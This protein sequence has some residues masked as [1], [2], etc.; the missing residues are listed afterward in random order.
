MR[1]L[2]AFALSLFVPAAAA[3]AAANVQEICTT[4]ANR[5]I[6][7]QK[8]NVQLKCGLSGPEW[9]AGFA[10]HFD[11]CVNGDNYKSADRWT[12]FRSERVAACKKA[13]GTTKPMGKPAS[14]DI[15]RT[16]ERYATQ[17]V[18]QHKENTSLECGLRGPEWNAGYAYHYAWCITGNNWRNASQGERLRSQKLAECRTAHA[19]TKPPPG[20]PSG[21][22]NSQWVKQVEPLTRDLLAHLDARLEQARKRAKSGT[23]WLTYKPLDVPAILAAGKAMSDAQRIKAFD[24][25]L[26]AEIA[27]AK[28]NVQDLHLP[29]AIDMVVTVPSGGRIEPGTALMIAGK[30]FGS[31]PGRIYLSYQTRRETPSTEFRKE[32]VVTETVDVAP[33][34]P[35]WADS[36][37]PT[38][39]VARVPVT[40]KDPFLEADREGV[41]Q[42]VL[43]DGATAKTT[44]TVG[45]GSPRIYEVKTADGNGWIRPG[46]EFVVIG[47]N[48]GD[49]P[50][51]TAAFSINEPG[52]MTL[53]RLGGS[54]TYVFDPGPAS[55]PTTTSPHIGISI[56]HW[57]NT[58]IGLKAGTYADKNFHRAAGAWVV[59]ENVKKQRGIKGGLF[60]GPDNL[61]KN[62]SGLEWIDPQAKKNKVGVESKDKSTLLV[63]HTPDCGF[64]DDSGEKGHD[65]FFSDPGWPKDV[66]VIGFTF[67]QIDPEDKYTDADFFVDQAGA[68]LEAAS[69]PIAFAKFVLGRVLDAIFGGGGGYHVYVSWGPDKLHWM[70]GKD[71]IVVSYE[72]DCSLGGRPIIY[73]MS[74]TIIGTK[75][76][77]AKH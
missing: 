59:I 10:Y 35:N 27:A 46:E 61:A 74:F 47:R 20:K 76:A 54:D 56:T 32:E 15:A 4:Y 8:Q 63:R 9:N 36:W 73:M 51:G 66:D 23:K 11:W 3:E 45:S 21:H 69:S 39:I 33:Y 60:F 38:L 17:A 75:E 58:R 68:L 62:V 55:P 44:L 24:A 28:R 64:W 71:P 12:E 14:S 67:K 48:F 50:G 18:A 25:S 72:S 7:Y 31:K 53:K 42:V 6:A 70:R 49:A 2:F 30:N 52:P 37:F 26:G 22:D 16:C 5:A 34:R 13:A 1:K 77:L 29:P 40:Y 41:L 43:P 65:S 57:S 19:I